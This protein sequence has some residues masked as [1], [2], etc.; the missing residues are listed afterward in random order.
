MKMTIHDLRL[1]GLRRP[2]LL[3]RAAR[4]GAADYNRDRDLNRLIGLESRAPQSSVLSR[5]IEKERTLDAARRA[6]AATYSVLRHVEIL[7][8]LM[9]EAQRA[10][11]P[12]GA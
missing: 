5:L 10:S 3:I 1:T 11:N 8:A 4:L 12:S 2:K 6:G 9:A 7:I